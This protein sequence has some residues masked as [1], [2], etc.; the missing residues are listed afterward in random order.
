MSTRAVFDRSQSGRVRSFF[1]T[2]KIEG[3]D[4][5][6]GGLAHG[7]DGA[8]KGT[9]RDEGGF[10]G[11]GDQTLLWVGLGARPLF[12]LSVILTWVWTDVRVKQS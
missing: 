7:F 1:G 8:Q 6:K 9:S 3:T 11:L 4:T 5:P 10:C 12:R 2:S